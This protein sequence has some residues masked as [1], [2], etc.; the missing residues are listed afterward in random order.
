MGC[1]TSPLLLQHT[2]IRGINVLLSVVIKTNE[3]F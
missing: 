3:A 2:V 1:D